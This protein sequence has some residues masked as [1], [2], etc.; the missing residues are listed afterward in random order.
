MNDKAN[1]NSANRITNDKGKSAAEPRRVSDNG[2]MTIYLKDNLRRLL[3]ARGIR[4]ADLSRQTGIAPSVIS[5][6]M[7]GR[8]PRN[9]SHLWKIAK[10]LGVS[11]DDLCFEETETLLRKDRY[12]KVPF[13]SP[14]VSKPDDLGA[15]FPMAVKFSSGQQFRVVLFPLAENIEASESESAASS[16]LSLSSV[17]EDG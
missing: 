5:E 8:M 6:W 15:I 10:H 2:T 12:E 7:S 3:M 17:M 13:G 11:M 14:N 4:A 16:S 1:K 9:I